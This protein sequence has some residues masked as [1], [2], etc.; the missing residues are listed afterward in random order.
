MK[1]VE[2]KV[3]IGKTGLQSSKMGFGAGVVGNAMM[4]PKMDDHKSEEL[5]YSALSHDIGMI[6]TAY[7]YGMGRSEELIGEVIR[8]Q[9][10]RDQ[11]ILSTKA[12][13]NPQ[14]GEDGLKV[15][16]SPS[17]LREAVNDSLKRL[18]TD[19]IDIFYLHFPNSSTPLLEAA[20]TLAQLKKEGKIRAV[21]ASNLSFEKLQEFNK[22]GYLDV[23]QAEYSL[24]V[25]TVEKDIIPYCLK[26]NISLIPFFPLASGLLAGAYKEDD[27]FTDTS[28]SNNPLFQKDAF[29]ANLKRVDQL[30]EFAKRREV[31]PA[32]IALAWL[33]TRPS[34][35][36]I[37]PG[38][39]RSDQINSNL[40]AL[41]IQLT[42]NELYKLDHIFDQNNE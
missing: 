33:L 5:L 23:L 38:A 6:D 32:Q 30:K 13:S 18:K 31:Q 34:V 39:T 8:K 4:Y 24:L 21:G 42:E 22:E 17:A 12:S 19:Y 1:N 10:V 26:N 7:L 16:N 25:R 29:L 9:G 15:D 3:C 41:N 28:R 2:N 27:V 40:Q 36:V 14:F 11:L 20:F 35:D 37:I